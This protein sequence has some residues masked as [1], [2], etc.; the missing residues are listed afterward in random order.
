MGEAAV[1]IDPDRPEAVA[2]LLI[3]LAND[4]GH[5]SALSEAGRRR[6]AEYFNASQAVA[7]V[8]AMRDEVLTRAGV[9]GPR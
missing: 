7:K 4:A 6:A 1:R 3:A 9:G 5:R 8:D 2:Q